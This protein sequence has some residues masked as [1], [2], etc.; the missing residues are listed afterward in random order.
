MSNPLDRL[1][2][3]KQQANENDNARELY[4]WYVADR[5]SAGW[6]P[7]DVAEYKEAVRVEMQS[8]EG[9]AMAIEFWSLKHAER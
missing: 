3:V 9:K 1:K 2:N 5:I 8:E 6:S 4:Q 7:E